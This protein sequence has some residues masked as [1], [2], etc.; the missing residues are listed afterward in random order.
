[1]GSEIDQVIEA[2]AE[3]YALVGLRCLE[4][5][6]QLVACRLLE[7]RQLKS[8]ACRSKCYRRASAGQGLRSTAAL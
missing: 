5:N 3:L 8:I 1:M 6:N 2:I 4:V 7:R